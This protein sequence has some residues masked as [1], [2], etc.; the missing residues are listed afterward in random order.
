MVNEQN[1]AH[2]LIAGLFLYNVYNPNSLL[3]YYLSPKQVI[4]HLHC[5]QSVVYHSL[6][7]HL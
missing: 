5:F 1:L 2:H 6:L 7:F 4:T 3:L